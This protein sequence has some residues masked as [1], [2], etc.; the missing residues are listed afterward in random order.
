MEPGQIPY[1]VKAIDRLQKMSCSQ[2]KQS[3][4]VEASVQLLYCGCHL[5]LFGSDRNALVPLVEVAH[6]RFNL[7]QVADDFQA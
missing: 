3:G 6:C 7:F 4:L 5:C 1:R 2:V